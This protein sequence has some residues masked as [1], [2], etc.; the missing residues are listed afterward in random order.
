V[1][2]G[3]RDDR[4]KIKQCRQVFWLNVVIQKRVPLT[5]SVIHCYLALSCTG[6]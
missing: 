5:L 2:D 6:L 3:Y 4:P 1:K